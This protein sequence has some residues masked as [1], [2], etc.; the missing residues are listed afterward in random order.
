MRG[1]ML[2]I[3]LCIGAAMCYVVVY[4]AGRIVTGFALLRE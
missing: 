3:I 4:D 1:D 2:W